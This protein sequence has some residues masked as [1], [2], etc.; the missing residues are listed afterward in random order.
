[1]RQWL[2][3]RLQ[4]GELLWRSN[5]EKNL[6]RREKSDWKRT[7]AS[8]VTARDS[9]TIMAPEVMCLSGFYALVF[10]ISDGL[11]V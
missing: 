8:N 9:P 1:M 2:H 6:Y 3:V 7:V 11:C 4:N 5:P 10:Q